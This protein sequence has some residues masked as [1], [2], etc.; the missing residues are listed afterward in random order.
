[1]AK[2]IPDF[3]LRLN[4]IISQLIFVTIF[5][6][7]FINVYHPF[8][9]TT[10]F[11]EG[12]DKSQ[13]FLYSLAVVGIGILILSI[14]RLTLFLLKKK[15]KITYLNYSVWIFAEIITMSFIYCLINKFA[16]QDSRDIFDVFPHTFIFSFFVLLIPYVVS[17]LYLALQEKSIHLEQALKMNKYIEKENLVEVIP[18]KLS[19]INFHDERGVLMLSISFENLYFIESADNYVNVYYENKGSIS[20]TILRR[21]L[22]SIEEEFSDYPIIRCHRSY[23]VNIKKIKM[24][25]KEKEGFIIDFDNEQVRDIPIS[26]TY[27]DK[28]LST[29]HQ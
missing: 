15:I 6:L 25:K 4:N 11:P 2:K 29:F 8:D 5:S 12:K 10:W 26:K 23:I 28:V 3:L 19:K 20:H 13:Y 17:W 14:S 1:M 7:I 16:L 21:N 24:I 18:N 27:S 9:S 22:K